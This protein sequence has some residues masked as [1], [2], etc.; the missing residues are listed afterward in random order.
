MVTGG[1][2]ALGLITAQWLADRGCR[3]ICLLGRTGR[4]LLLCVALALL[5][6]LLA[7]INVYMCFVPAQHSGCEPCLSQHNLPQGQ[8][9]AKRHPGSSHEQPLRRSCDSS[10]L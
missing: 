2:G 10:A 4:C 7:N 8:R 6:F 3:H 1:L 9:R 5:C